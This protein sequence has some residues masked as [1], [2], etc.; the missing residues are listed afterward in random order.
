M[1]RAATRA[2]RR[3][4]HASQGCGEPA[5]A[6]RRPGRLHARLRPLSCRRWARSA[7]LGGA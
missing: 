7:A 4:H 5:F 3:Y 1:A 2:L 6:N